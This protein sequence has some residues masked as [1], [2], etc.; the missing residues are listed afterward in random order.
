[1]NGDSQLTPN[2]RLKNERLLRGWTREYIAER[3]GS[4][5]KTV[6]RWERGAT[7][8]QSYYRQKLCELF[9]MNAW[10]LGLLRAEEYAAMQ[11]CAAAP[12]S[13]LD[14]RGK[15]GA[16]RGEGAGREGGQLALVSSGLALW[17]VKD[18]HA[19]PTLLGLICVGVL[20][21][22]PSLFKLLRMH[23]G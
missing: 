18:R 4:D 8:P 20:I 15:G 5:L 12:G 21:G 13:G 16:G 22:M 23:G 1:M 3:V 10:E 11:A 14:A 9:G 7:C 6:G 2:V 17:T 19:M